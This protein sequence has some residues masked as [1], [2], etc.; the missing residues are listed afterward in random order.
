LIRGGWSVEPDDPEDDEEERG[1]WRRHKK[2]LSD[3]E[4]EN[5]PG[6]VYNTE[7]YPFG[8][9]NLSLL[10]QPLK[11][12][13]NVQDVQIYTTPPAEHN[14]RVGR[15]LDNYCKAMM[16]DEGCEETDQQRERDRETLEW[17]TEFHQV[18]QK[19]PYS[20]RLTFTKPSS[21]KRHLREG[22]TISTRTFHDFMRLPVGI[23]KRVMSFL[24]PDRAEIKVP[25]SM[26]A[27]W[28]GLRWSTDT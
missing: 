20:E 19:A 13:R 6:R 16:S 27:G 18:R 1:W 12:L 11:L 28:P 14:E 9:T 21:R 5:V 2:Y 23:R 17:L 25:Q 7:K 26:Q 24:L 10:L 8:A 22:G 15:T 4:V 3:N